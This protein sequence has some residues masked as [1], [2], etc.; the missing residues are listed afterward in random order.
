RGREVRERGREGAD[1]SA[2]SGARTESEL[3]AGSRER[4]RKA[5]EAGAVSER[6]GAEGERRE[7]WAS[8]RVLRRSSATL[9][10]RI[11]DRATRSRDRSS[12]ERNGPLSKPAECAGEVA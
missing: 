11:P 3:G 8:C 4:G 5:S 7:E 6:A 9:P 10:T 2:K 1:G 12:T